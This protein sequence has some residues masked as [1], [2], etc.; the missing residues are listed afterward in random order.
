MTIL[1]I[2]HDVTAEYGLP[3]P[4]ILFGS[5][6]VTAKRLAA[7]AQRNGEALYRA[8]RWSMLDRE[9]EFSTEAAV[10]NYPIPDD[11]GRPVGDTVWDR[12][13]YWRVRG[14]L[15]SQ[16]WQV[17]RSGLT[18][19][20]GSRF[21]YRLIMGPLVGSILIDPVPGAVHAL[22]I[23]Y[24]SRWWS[25]SAAGQ[26]QLTLAADTD[27]IRLDHELFTL[28][29]TWRV[30]RAFG[31]AYADERADYESAVNTARLDDYNL[32]MFSMGGSDEVESLGVPDGGFPGPGNP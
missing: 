29:M 4:I 28:G 8:H 26:G 23:E 15:G 11:W 5:D 27:E 32:P 13:N 7:I 17:R 24:G 3:Q 12:T 2:V 22:V 6:D 1:S 31:R 14:N 25:E 30:L 9:Y 19:T 10:D 18:A 20:L 16:Q 21:G